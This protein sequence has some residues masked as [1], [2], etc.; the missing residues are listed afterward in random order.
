[1]RDR[2]VSTVLIGVE[3]SAGSEDAI[4]FAGRLG[5]REPVEY[6]VAS[7]YSS[8]PTADSGPIAESHEGRARRTTR[9]M[10][11]L[12]RDV[13]AEDV[14]TVVASDTAPGR[15]LQ[16][17]AARERAA[18]IVVGAPR[19]RSLG[20][21]LDS[22]TVEHLLPGAPCPVAVVPDG[23]RISGWSTVRRIGVACDGSPES[24][25][26]IAAGIAA[27]RGFDAQVELI[28]VAQ[29]SR[30]LDAEQLQRLVDAVPA[31]VEA[32]G[33]H[34]HGDAVEALVARTS[35]IDLLVIGSR[36]FGPMR[37]AVAGGVSQRVIREARCP[38]IVIPSGANAP[39]GGLFTASPTHAQRAGSERD[40]PA[41]I[42]AAFD[43]V[44]R[45]R[46]PLE[47]A[48]ALHEIVGEP[49]IAGAIM[50]S[51]QSDSS[52]VAHLHEELGVRS[53]TIAGHSVPHELHALALHEH[54][55]LIVV[56]STHR[57]R[58]G[59]VLPGSTAERL[60]HEA[61]CPVALAPH[62][63]RRAPIRSV[64]V[65]YVDTPEGRAALT[66][67]H[68]LARAA[69][70]RL[71]AVAVT[72]PRDGLDAALARDAAARHRARLDD[73]RVREARERLL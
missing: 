53:I 59:C 34:L 14:R 66:A 47:L 28:A 46:A 12:L 30:G 5:G 67:A 29:S 51:A 43:P 9:R 6:V 4:A 54:A 20:R 35:V 40:D 32:R 31:G 69:G 72:R 39:P 38:V 13:P 42:V 60:L 49:V 65:G 1:M 64:A 41:P 73:Q 3:D 15:G 19:S 45:D 26:A 36:G 8:P 25:E 57:A 11:G 16:R 52:P 21:F 62:G 55:G 68:H 48:I 18:L 17:L 63:Y 50:S 27:A 37:S 10:S 61:P 70:A 7:V 22:A 23:F 58:L 2:A 44:R 24:E 56:G 33:E 71:R